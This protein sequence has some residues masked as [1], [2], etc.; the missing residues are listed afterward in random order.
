[1]ASTRKTAAVLSLATGAPIVLGAC[2]RRPGRPFLFRIAMFEPPNH[3]A[4][5]TAIHELTAAVVATLETWIRDDPTPWRR[6]DLRWKTRPDG[7]EEQYGRDVVQAF[8]PAVSGGPEGPHYIDN[9]TRD[10]AR[11]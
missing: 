1:P 5:G 8:R 6:V 11:G 7:S 3:L 4:A 2:V 9:G 10:H